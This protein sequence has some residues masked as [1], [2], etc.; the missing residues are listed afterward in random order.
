MAGEDVDP[1]NGFGCLGEGQQK[2][3]QEEGTGVHRKG[4]RG[5]VGGRYTRKVL[6]AGAAKTGLGDRSIIYL[7][8]QSVSEEEGLNFS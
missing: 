5:S 2:C 3:P 7:M 1:E 8:I 4:C 6:F